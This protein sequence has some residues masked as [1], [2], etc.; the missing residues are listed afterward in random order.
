M[1][2]REYL[3]QYDIEI[4]NFIKKGQD[5]STNDEDLE[6]ILLGLFLCKK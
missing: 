4:K 6:D 1:V 5:V 2:I 3:R